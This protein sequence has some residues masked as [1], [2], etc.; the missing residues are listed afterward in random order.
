[1]TRLLIKICAVLF[2]S[3]HALACEKT[4]LTR[5]LDDIAASQNFEAVYGDRF[6]EVN[7]YASYGSPYVLDFAANLDNSILFLARKRNKF[8]KENSL[9]NDLD[10]VRYYNYFL[11]FASKANS[12][13]SYKVKEVIENVGLMGMSVFYGNSINIDSKEFSYIKS[14][15]KIMGSDLDRNKLIGSGA[16]I[17][18]GLSSTTTLLYYDGSL[19]RH[20]ERDW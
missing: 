6:P 10:L 20:V 17:I 1:M 3:T 2:L 19:I 14:N 11:I 18:S 9:D 13:K 15:R 12:S 5:L 7:P 16:V 4:K 8:H